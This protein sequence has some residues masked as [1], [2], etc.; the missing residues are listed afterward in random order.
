MYKL[1]KAQFQYFYFSS[2]HLTIWNVSRL[3]EKQIK[4][5]NSQHRN[6]S[7]YVTI[8]ESRIQIS[9]LRFEYIKSFKSDIGNSSIGMSTCNRTIFLGDKIKL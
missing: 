6:R 5:K 1:Y 2:F 4:K 9:R 8:Y 7:S 3:Y